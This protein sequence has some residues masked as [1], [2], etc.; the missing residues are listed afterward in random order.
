ME[1]C[2]YHEASLIRTKI[3]VVLWDMKKW[4][5]ITQSSLVKRNFPNPK[6]KT[7]KK[8]DNSNLKFPKV[9]TACRYCIKTDLKNINLSFKGPSSPS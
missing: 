4:L 5:F 8:N 2:S 1:K 7:Y 3:S 9:H 6:E